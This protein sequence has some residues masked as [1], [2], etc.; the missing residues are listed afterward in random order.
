MVLKDYVVGCKLLLNYGF[1]ELIRM[2]FLSGQ[3]VTSTG[4]ELEFLVRLTL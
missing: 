2:P 1:I 3:N 4:A